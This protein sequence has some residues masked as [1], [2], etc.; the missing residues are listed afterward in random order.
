M[1]RTLRLAAILSTALVAVTASAQAPAPVAEPATLIH[2]GTL[3]AVP[4]QAPR[5]NATIVVRAGKGGAK[6]SA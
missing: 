1:R 6:W 4:G 5:R 3:L 2:A